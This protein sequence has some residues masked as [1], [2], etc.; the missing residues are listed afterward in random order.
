MTNVVL[1]STIYLLIGASALIWFGLAWISD[2]NL[3]L[4]KDFFSLVPKVVS[5]DLLLIAIFVKWCW[6]FKIFRGWLVPFPDLNGTWIG[7]IYSNWID[8]ETGEKIKPIPVMLTVKQNLFSASYVVR[9]AEMQSDSYVEG[10]LID[11]QR[12]R[13]ELTY[14]YTSKPRVSVAHRS[15]PHDGACVLSIIESP[16]RKLSGRY[17]TERQ[18]TG[19][20][21]FEFY[22][23]EMLEELPEDHRDHPKTEIENR[24]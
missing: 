1:K 13:K 4:A 12:Q 16:K 15:N 11:E 19:E 22:S 20:M 23:E 6:K 2:L 9:T 24:R 8:E 3:S 14:S 21:I 7:H 10:F 18:T 17:W 5:V